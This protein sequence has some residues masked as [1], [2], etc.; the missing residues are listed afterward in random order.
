MMVT[1][2]VTINAYITLAPNAIQQLRWLNTSRKDD[3]YDDSASPDPIFFGSSSLQVLHLGFSHLSLKFE[4]LTFQAWHTTLECP[5]Y[6]ARNTQ[7]SFNTKLKIKSSTR[8][9]YKAIAENISTRF[10][11]LLHTSCRQIYLSGH[12]LGGG[13]LPTICDFDIIAS[14]LASSQDVFVTIFGSPKCG[15]FAW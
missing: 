3:L 2:Y 5:A 12:S 11:A 14:G 15:D 10:E 4:W 6:L 9:L 8:T 1:T 13:A 7:S